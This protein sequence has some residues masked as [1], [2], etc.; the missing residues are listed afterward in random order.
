[1]CDP[2]AVCNANTAWIW[3]NTTISMLIICNLHPNG[4]FVLTKHP[5]IYFNP[6]YFNSLLES[7]LVLHMELSEN[8]GHEQN[9][10]EY[11][12]YLR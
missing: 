6:L 2:E 5:F 10:A 7:D 1:M 11:E 3:K 9:L 12:K 4:L 8:A